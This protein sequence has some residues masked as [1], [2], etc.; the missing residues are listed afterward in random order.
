M[1][2]IVKHGDKRER[3]LRI[4]ME[5]EPKTGKTRF[6]TSLPWGDYWGQ[7]AIYVAADPGAD[8]LET[9]SV[10]QDNR[11]HLIVIKPS[12]ST[13]KIKVKGPDG[14]EEHEIVTYDPHKEAF[15][16]ASRNWRKEF[17][18]AKTLIWDTMTA[19]ARELLYAYADNG[20]FQGDK[21]DKHITVGEVNTPEFVANPMMGDYSMAQRA[22]Q[23]LL[24][25]LFKQQMHVIVLFHIQAVE[26]DQGQVLAFGPATVGQASVRP[27]ASLFDN[28]LRTDNIEVLTHDKPPKKETKYILHTQRK[29]LYLGGIRT[30]HAKNPV[31]QI[32]ISEQPREAWETLTKVLKG[33]Q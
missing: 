6:A 20:I 16:I 13:K 19:T 30:G 11:E 21:G 2:E 8:D 14:F 5:G 23:N 28:L 25:F 10:L 31:P 12:Y 26:T 15:A 18:E 33:E 32:A 27:V 17:P 7:Q 24:G 29:G 22:V 1:P 4:G 3:Y 9:S